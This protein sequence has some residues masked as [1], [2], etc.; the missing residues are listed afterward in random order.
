MFGRG[1]LTTVDNT[2]YASTANNLPWL[3]S[4]D[5]QTKNPNFVYNIVYTFSPKVVNEFNV[6]AAGWY[7]HGLQPCGCGKGHLGRRRLSVFRSLYAGVNPLNLFP[8]TSFGGTNPVNYGW[9]SRFPF[10]DRVKTY[11]ATDNVTWIWGN[12]SFKFGVDAQ[13]DSYLQPNHN[14]VGTFNTNTNSSNPY[15]TNWGYA[16]AL[17]GTLNTYSQTTKLVNYL[18]RTNALEW[19][20]QDTWKVN[21]KLTLDLGIRNSWAMAQRASPGR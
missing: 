13:T 5:Y 12:H 11:S 2:G 1:D 16:N 3:I 10:A 4:D 17:V 15:D 14:Q 7:E 9:D 21:N 19:Y 20:Y 18:P 6:G 8:T